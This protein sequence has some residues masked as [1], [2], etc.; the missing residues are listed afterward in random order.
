M[1]STPVLANEQ[2]RAAPLTQADLDLLEAQIQEEEKKLGV[3]RESLD[4]AALLTQRLVATLDGFDERIGELDPVIMPIFRSMQGISVVNSSMQLGCLPC[5][6]GRCGRDG[7][8][9]EEDRG[10][11]RV[12]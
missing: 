2:K 6:K 1:L 10:L 4:R 5:L 12:G 3:V 9:A 8:A 11:Q 7:G